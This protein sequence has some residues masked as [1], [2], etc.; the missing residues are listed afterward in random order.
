VYVIELYIV[1]YIE[2]R[3]YCEIVILSNNLTT[4]NFFQRKKPPRKKV[5][6]LHLLPFFLSLDW[7]TAYAGAFLLYAR[8]VNPFVL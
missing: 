7:M 2:N 4:V 5:S 1:L 8:D 3:Y 6:S